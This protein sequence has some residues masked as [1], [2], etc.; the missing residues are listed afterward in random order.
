[1]PCF[2]IK[3]IYIVCRQGLLEEFSAVYNKMPEIVKGNGQGMSI[4]AAD[5]LF[6]M[7]IIGSIKIMAPF[8][9][10]GVIVAFVVSIVQV[11]WKSQYQADAAKV[12][13]V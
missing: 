7:S 5:Q 1:M 12:E 3:S 10:V 9:A 13:Q 6:R 4:H 2:G 11:G 8:L